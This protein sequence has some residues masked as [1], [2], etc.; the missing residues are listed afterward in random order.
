MHTFE[1]EQLVMRES[2]KLVDRA[3]LV[4]QLCKSEL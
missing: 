4:L 3:E 1:I 2:I